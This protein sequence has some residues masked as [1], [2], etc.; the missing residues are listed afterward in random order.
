MQSWPVLGGMLSESRGLV[1]GRGFAS[2]LGGATWGGKH[3]LTFLR[4]SSPFM[5]MARFPKCRSIWS[6]ASCCSMTSS[7]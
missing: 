5:C 1:H 4:T 6:V 3:T 2:L 7:P